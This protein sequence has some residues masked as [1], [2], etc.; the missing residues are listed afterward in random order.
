MMALSVAVIRGKDTFLYNLGIVDPRYQKPVN[1]NTVFRAASL[2]K[3]VFAYLVVKLAEEGI[4]ELDKPLYKY[5]K[6]PFP[7][8]PDYQDLKGD[9]FLPLDWLEY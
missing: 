6:H 2:S 4:V 9:T 7:E 3:P 5:L 1:N 8:Y